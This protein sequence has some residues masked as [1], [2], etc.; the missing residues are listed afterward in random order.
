MSLL[1]DIIEDSDC[2]GCFSPDMR[3]DLLEKV[4]AGEMASK[5][6]YSR[7][8][9]PIT[10]P[11]MIEV[12]LMTGYM[13]LRVDYRDK[14]SQ[15]FLDE[16]VLWCDDSPSVDLEDIMKILHGHVKEGDNLDF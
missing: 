3:D 10:C 16:M 11:D 5:S 14:P 15:Y 4:E 2:E 13:P 6:D 7:C 1:D 9:Q 8:L 12:L